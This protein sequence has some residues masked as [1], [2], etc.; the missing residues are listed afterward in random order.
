MI[1]ASIKTKKT[2]SKIFQW[3][4]SSY[5]HIFPPT[6]HHSQLPSWACSISTFYG[7]AFYNIASVQQCLLHSKWPSSGQAQYDTFW[8][9]PIKTVS[10]SSRVQNP[11]LH[12]LMVLD[13]DPVSPY[14]GTAL[15]YT[16]WEYLPTALKWQTLKQKEWYCFGMT[17]CFQGA[18]QIYF[19]MNMF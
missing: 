18:L 9:E 16:N 13:K 14:E 17:Q 10:M 8:I 2:S 1:K 11:G 7:N 4:F 15:L 3:F 19:W 6:S 12:D 5:L